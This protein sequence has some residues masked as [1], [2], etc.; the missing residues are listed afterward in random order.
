MC[1]DKNERWLYRFYLQFT[2]IFQMYIDFH[3]WFLD[4]IFRSY[5]FFK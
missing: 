5:Q 2:G 4:I 1:G 3:S